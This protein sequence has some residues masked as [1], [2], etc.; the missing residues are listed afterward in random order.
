L[1]IKRWQLFWFNFSALRRAHHLHVD[2][3][4]LDH[5]QLVAR[6]FSSTISRPFSGRQPGGKM[7]R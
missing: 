1:P 5:A 7:L 3:A 4:G 2:L 6:A